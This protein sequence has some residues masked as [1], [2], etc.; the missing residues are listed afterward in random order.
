MEV[1]DVLGA[2]AFVCCLMVVGIVGRRSLLR[3]TGATLD[4]CLR[5]PGTT[6]TGLGPRRGQARR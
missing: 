4:L 6:A 5:Y 1:V 2:I 3:R